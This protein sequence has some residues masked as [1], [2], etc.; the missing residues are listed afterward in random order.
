MDVEIKHI[1]TA[2]GT[3]LLYFS[4][5]GVPLSLIDR[6]E[7][8]A[9]W[10][11]V[12]V[13]DYGGDT[14]QWPDLSHYSRLYL[15]AWSMGVWASEY[16]RDCYPT[17]ERAVAVCGTP[18]LISNRYGIRE[19]DYQQMA[20]SLDEEMYHH[21]VR[22]MCLSRKETSDFLALLG[23]RGTLAYRE[24][25]RRVEKLGGSITSCRVPWTKALIGEKDLVI[26]PAGQRLFWTE[27]CIAVT[28]L[29]SA[30][31]LV[32]GNHFKSWRDLFNC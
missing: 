30:P 8:P 24:E 17:P 21:F 2:S 19:A 25:L 4:G 12:S 13:S 32:F 18:A 20:S 31:H 5:W 26:P 15:V 9:E 11:L 28:T 29:P 14:I 6:M 3:A 16:Y 1:G 27:R 23:H 7:L 10:T 22:Q